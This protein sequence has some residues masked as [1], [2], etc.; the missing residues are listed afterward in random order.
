MKKIKIVYLSNILNHYQLA[1]SKGFVKQDNV[2][3]YFI[4]TTTLSEE[5]KKLNIPEYNHYAEWAVCALDS[6]EEEKRAYKLFQDADAAIFGMVPKKYK[7]FLK[8]RE[9]ANKPIFF[10]SERIYK[11]KPFFLEMPLRFVLYFFRHT[12]YRNNYMLCASAFTYPDYRKTLN[13]YNKAFRWGYFSEFVE[14][15]IDDLFLKKDSKKTSIV[16][17]GRFLSWK[18]PEAMVYLG[19]YL[20]EKGYSF[21]IKMIGVGEELPKIAEMINQNNLTE[22]IKLIGSLS[23]EK[24]R[25]EMDKSNIFVFSSDRGEGWGLV[26]NEAMN[27]GC[28]VV[29]SNTIGSVPYLISN[30]V[31]GL[32]FESENWNDLCVKVESVINDFEKQRKLGINAYLTIKNMWNPNIAAERFVSLAQNVLMGKGSPFI[33]DGPCSLAPKKIKF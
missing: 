28:V 19:K 21:D 32:M 31:N 24:V 3:Y 1:L 20:K 23:P 5:R 26:L 8:D 25:N 22:E 29:G 2:E 6:E 27:S 11:E 30:G 14:Y 4:S 9:K 7:Y 12:I 33:D 15:S 18:H 17:T 10:A 13:Y 16:W